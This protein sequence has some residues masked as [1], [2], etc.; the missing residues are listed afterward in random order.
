[1]NFFIIN[2][3]C[4]CVYEH[5]G[6]CVYDVCVSLHSGAPAGIAGFGAAAG[7]DGPEGGVDP[8]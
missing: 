8:Q 7:Q 5:M 6:L 2:I 1:M 3:V 4:V